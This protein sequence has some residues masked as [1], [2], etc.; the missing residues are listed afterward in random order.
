MLSKPVDERFS[1]ESKCLVST[2]FVLSFIVIVCT[3]LYFFINKW[4]KTIAGIGSVMNPVLLP[5]ETKK[6]K[7][8]I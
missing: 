1:D 7:E 4:L 8:N 6:E 3:T 5:V 2:L